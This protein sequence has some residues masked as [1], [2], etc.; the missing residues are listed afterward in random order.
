MQPTPHTT[1]DPCSPH[2]PLQ[3]F[4]SLVLR[5]L[6]ALSLLPHSSVFCFPLERKERENTK[7]ALTACWSLP[8]ALC[9]HEVG[10]VER[11]PED[12]MI[13]PGCGIW[14][15]KENSFVFTF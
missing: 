4:D 1:A 9:S 13:L 7:G 14:L 11:N 6:E 3:I 8:C 2:P 12:T 15:G 10:S 5:D